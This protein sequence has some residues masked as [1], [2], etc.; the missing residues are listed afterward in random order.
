MT[1][2]NQIRLLKLNVQELGSVMG[3]GL[4]AAIRPAIVA[5]NTFMNYLIAA[6]KAFRTFMFT[7][8]G[9]LASFGKGIVNDMAGIADMGDDL[10][11]SL[12]GGGGGGAADGLG[13]A[14]KNAAKLKKQLTVLPFDELNQLAK[15]MDTAAGAGSSPGGGGGGV[16]GGGL[17]DF[18]L[19][20]SLLNIDELL[21]G[22]KAAE[23]ISRWGQM[24]KKAFDKQDWAGLGRAMAWG[25]NLGINQLYKVLDRNKVKEKVFPFID[26]FTTTFNSLVYS[27]NFGLLGQALGR[28]INDIVMI[29]DRFLT[30]INFQ[31]IGK[32]IG[33]FLN[34]MVS[35]VDWP[36]LGKFFGD[37]I[38]SVIDLAYGAVTT[39]DWK[40]FGSSIGSSING[41]IRT[42]N[43]AEAATTL[44]EAFIGLFDTI[45]SAIAEIDW[46][47]FGKDVA[48]F[49]GNIDFAGA[50]KAFFGA[51][52]T[53]LGGLAEFLYG[54]LEDGFNQA[55]ED[56][57][58]AIEDCG[59]NVI[60]GLLAGMAQGIENVATWIGKNIFEPI[61]SGIE[62]VF[63]I[64]SPSKAMEEP[65]SY[66]G[67][68]LL[69]GME[70]GVSDGAS[71]Y[72]SIK[73][74]IIGKFSEASTWLKPSGS[75]L[76]YGLRTGWEASSGS[77]YS[78]FEGMG[79]TIKK[80][81]G[82]LDKT[83]RDIASD[84]GSGFS[85]IKK[86]TTS[87]MSDTVSEVKLN[88][89]LMGAQG[90][91]VASAFTTAFASGMNSKTLA[92]TVNT[93]FKSIFNTLND[94]KKTLGEKGKEAGAAY[95]NGFSKGFNENAMKTEAT[96]A[97]NTIVTTLKN[98]S[99]SFTDA[100]R[101][102]G[103]AFGNAFNTYARLAVK[104]PKLVQKGSYYDSKTKTTIPTYNIE[105]NAEGGLFERATVL[106][107][108]GEAGDEA[109]IPLTNK[110]AMRKIANA[111]ID[112]ANGFGFDPAMLA[113]AVEYG[114]SNAMSG[115]NTAENQ[116]FYI[117]VKTQND[118]VLARAVQRGNQKLSRRYNPSV[119]I[120]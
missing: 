68:G 62:S 58:Q 89:E 82:S 63:E 102:L 30:G 93:A 65:G 91:A 2:A 87:T 96:G 33:Q 77:V 45:S 92:S 72:D 44:S 106:N 31:K 109:A 7:I 115:N 5:L 112:G 25:I 52:G 118:E 56:V 110:R 113:E 71:Y 40:K 99:G 35:E 111:I 70:D 61:L 49:L 75:S 37:K 88:V 108:F 116:V 117:E 17:G 85:D 23:A 103:N 42:I 24:I 55:V 69:V 90:R 11:S 81:V 1:Y 74:T 53:A 107:G 104:T 8:F 105:W 47:G 84:F 54:L 41:F 83:G 16:G 101:T 57:Q 120:A 13:K 86:D 34:G 14:A 28:G 22:N 29:A 46:E 73:Q 66:I 64:G 119:S 100:G 67:Q 98:S 97:I 60:A 59:G 27:I 10:S 114:V 36:S 95:T 19:D 9:K 48:D 94:K 78:R 3:Q 51:L 15:D 39:F 20:D 26:A 32:K 50:A 38:M 43:W 79:N 12:G 4:I 6:A 21:K 18:G 76:A 80:K